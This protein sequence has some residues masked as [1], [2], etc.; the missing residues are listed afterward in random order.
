LFGV[1]GVAPALG[2]TFTS[3]DVGTSNV[4][5]SDA[6]WRSRFHADLTVVGRTIGGADQTFTIIGVMPRE[7]RFPLTLEADLFRVGVPSTDDRAARMTDLVARLEPGVTPTRA[8]AELDTLSATL[9]RQVP[10]SNAGWS[11][12]IEPLTGRPSAAYRAAFGTLLGM[13]GLFL[14]IACANLASLLVV[15]NLARRVE[16]TV[17]MAIGASRWR[18]ARGLIVESAF[19]AMAGGALAI[20][21][22]SEATHVFSLWLP[23]STPRLGDLRITGV[24]LAF[25]GAASALTAGLCTLAP[26]VGLRTLR[27]NESMSGTR[28]AVPTARAGQQV[29]V[30]V[31]IALAVVLL[32]GASTMVRT[33]GEL[34]ARDRGYVPSGVATMTVALAFDQAKYEVPA[35]RAEAVSE[36]LASVASVPGVTVAGGVTGF[37]GSSLGILGGGPVTVPG[38]T[39][40]PVIAA[41]HAATPDYFRA[42]GVA[43]LRGRFFTPDDR[44]ARPRVAIVNEALARQLWP[45]GSGVG[46]RLT[47][48]AAVGLGMTLDADADIVGVVADMHLGVSRSADVFVPFAQVPSFWFDLVARTPGDPAAVMTAIGQAIHRVE[49]DA[50]VEHVSPMARVI[51]DVYGLQRAQSSL[52][53]LVAG[54][55]GLIA[56]LGLY[57]LLTQYVARRRR[58]LGIRL[59]LGSSPGRLFWHVVQRGLVLSAVGTGLGLAA[60]VI[61]MR[62]LRNEVFGLQ[63]AGPWFLA[64]IAAAIGASCA[65]VIAMSA[66]RVV[67]IDPIATLRDA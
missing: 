49:P 54:L 43:L 40:P 38:R 47:V 52:T 24:V 22:A 9:A 27:I 4:V 66:R 10:K 6:L 61:V 51:S 20:A 17:T 23:P 53:A 15:R 13:A 65:V 29:L 64:A 19:V 14:V 46:R 63:G 8:Q 11:L 7:F 28:G 30:A 5:L 35:T 2:R 21:V 39:A 58:E 33:F 41:L 42:M 59:A 34:L 18:L 48:P 44:A 12:Q 1:L 67:A 31:E 16:L 26:I 45:D 62:A 56:L 3:G 60:A 55:G 57:A 50:L 37:P 36:V 25:A 32:V